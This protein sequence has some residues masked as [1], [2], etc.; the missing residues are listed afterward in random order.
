MMNLDYVNLVLSGL[1]SDKRCYISKNLIGPNEGYYVLNL[2]CYVSEEYFNDDAVKSLFNGQYKSIEELDEAQELD[3]DKPIHLQ[4][5]EEEL[6]YYTE[7]G[8][9]EEIINN[10]LQNEY[11]FTS[12]GT[13]HYT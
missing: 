13:I 9:E 4:M 11:Y 6:Y 8:D 5:Q 1:A 3:E 2:G 10:I 7:N 12:D